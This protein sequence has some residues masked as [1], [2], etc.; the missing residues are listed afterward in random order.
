MQIRAKPGRSTSKENLALSYN[1]T[2][3]V[4]RKMTVQLNFTSA[5]QVSAN[6]PDT[7][8]AK[9]VGNFFFFDQDGMVLPKDKTIYKELPLQMQF[10]SKATA[11]LVAVAEVANS[12]SNGVLV[13]NLALNIVLSASLQQLWSMVNTQ[14]LVVLMPLWSIKLP[15]NAAMFF[16]FIMTIAAFDILPT[17]TF[18]NNY[19]PGMAPT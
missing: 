5:I 13:S 14:Q 11:A 2:E 15:A 18:Y 7:L 16:G 4:E 6:D 12:A 17:D 10:G 19:F 9:F 3:Y 1:I 8:E